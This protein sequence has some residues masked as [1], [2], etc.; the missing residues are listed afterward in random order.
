VSNSK[1]RNNAARIIIEQQARE[2]RRKRALL[3]SA[4]ALAVLVIAGLISWAVVASQKAGAVTTPPTAIDGGTGFAD[5]NGP[6]KVDIYE[7]FMCP[8]CGQFEKQGG[9]T[10]QQLAKDGK[11]TIVYH[12]IAI[13][14]RASSTEYSTRAAAAAAAASEA[15][16]FIEFHDALFA[17]QPEENSAGLSDQKL[18]DIGTSVGITD[19]AFAKSITDKTYRT[20]ATKVT[21]TASS[22]GVTGTPTVIVAGK[23]IKEP[24]PEA[25]TA[26]VTAAAG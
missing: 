25:L 21:D 12:P 24:T 19:S 6:V 13:L 4:I 1:G 17:Q 23:Q 14:D 8:I 7:D 5:G 15:K 16:K 11:V 18:I 10:L 22:R 2:R 9:A 3:T 20:W 26:A